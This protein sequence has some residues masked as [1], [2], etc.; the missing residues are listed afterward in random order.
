M[1][2]KLQDLTELFA[3][4]NDPCDKADETNIIYSSFRLCFQGNAC[5]KP[6]SSRP[7]SCLYYLLRGASKC[8]M[9]RL[10]DYNGNSYPAYCDFT[11]EPGTAWTLVMS[12]SVTNRM[13]Y[14]FRG[15]PFKYNA[16]LNENFLNWNVYRLNL[17][18]TESLKTHSTHWRATCNYPTLGVDFRDYLRGN[19]K[20]FNIFDFVGDGTCKKVDYINIR[21]YRG[22]HLTAPFWQGVHKYN[23]HIDSSLSTSCDFKA[24]RTGAVSSED[25]FGHYGVINSKFRCTQGPR[26]TTQWWF[27]AHI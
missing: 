18:R 23:L 24:A 5:P 4:E 2:E 9:Y 10:Y 22:F 13:L 27:G 7:T 12:W 26:S 19:F 11:S 1:C 15:L 6:L 17:V 8:G 16:P 14:P 21:G 3:V 25:N 20:D